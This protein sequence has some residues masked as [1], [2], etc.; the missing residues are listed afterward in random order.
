MKFIHTSN[1]QIGMSPDPDKFW[2]E[3]RAK[4]IKETFSNVISECKEEGIDLLLIS[5]NLF[6]H[7][8][9]SIELDFVNDLFKSIPETHVLIVAGSNDHIKSNSPILNYK[10]SNNVHYFLNNTIDSYSIDSKNVVVHGLSYYSLEDPS[11]IINSASSD[12]DDQAHILMFFGGDSRHLPFDINK[13]DE[14]GFSYVALGLK[15]NYQEVIKNKMYYPGAP[16]PLDQN[17]EGDHGII[18]GEIDDKT[19]ELIN[20]SF[21]KLAKAS[22][23]PI[24]AK[25]NSKTSEAD[26]VTLV[27]KEVMRLGDNNIYKVI[28]EGMRDPDIEFYDNM[29]SKKIKIASFEDLSNPKYDF[30]KL[31][32]EHPQDMIGAFIR[33][34]TFSSDNPSDIEKNALYFGTHALLKSTERDD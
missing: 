13:L 17:D 12:F 18:I 28:I 3:A 29:F 26:V 22:Y 7:Q 4:D 19:H 5:G 21:K 20:V 27:T 8:A 11:S 33:K 15:H 34:M 30:I 24:V 32:S 1:I 23:I 10:F 14:K 25:V 6:N 16:E 9:T 31:S 2:S